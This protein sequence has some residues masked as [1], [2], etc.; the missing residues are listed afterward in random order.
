MDFSRFMDGI[1][2]FAQAHVWIVILI[3]LGLIFFMIRKPK[4]FFS[5]LTLGLIL[6]GLFYLV[7]NMAGSGS[8]KKSKLIEEKE[9]Q[10]D[11]NP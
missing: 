1:V 7:A 10:V 2:S 9:E 5:L 4:L 3:I 11:T 6:A 8:E